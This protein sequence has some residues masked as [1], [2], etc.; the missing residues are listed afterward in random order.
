MNKRVISAEEFCNSLCGFIKFGSQTDDGLKYV[1][2]NDESTIALYKYTDYSLVACNNCS[3]DVD[4][5]KLLKRA[6]A[7]AFRKYRDDFD[8]SD[9]DFW[10]YIEPKIQQEL[11]LLY[12]TAQPKAS[13]F[14]AYKITDDVK[15]DQLRAAWRD[16]YLI[17]EMINKRDFS[18]LV[19][20]RL[21]YDDDAQ[22]YIK[23]TLEIDTK[24]FFREKIYK[25]QT[26]RKDIDNLD[27]FVQV[28]DQKIFFAVLTWMYNRI[29]DESNLWFIKDSAYK[30]IAVKLAASLS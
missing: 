4:D 2:S 24:L 17:D 25:L 19:K 29:I 9:P 15:T 27:D 11:E 20:N 22:D 3:T 7:I 10:I 8:E 13:D 28:K 30:D 6:T 18:S 1:E 26:L 16:C 21:V 12:L 23:K 5:E 14:V